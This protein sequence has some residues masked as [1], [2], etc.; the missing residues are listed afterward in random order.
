MATKTTFSDAEFIAL[1]ADYNLGV[2]SSATPIS[3]GTVQTNYLLHP[4]QDRFI[5]RYYENRTPESVIFETNLLNYL[6]TRHFPCPAPIKNKRGKYMSIYRA[7]PFAIF[8]FAEGHQLEHPTDAQQRQLIQHVA[9]LQ[10]ITKGYRPAHRSARWNYGI[11]LC[12]QLA[13]DAAS[14][15]NTP[16]AHAKLAWYESTLQTLQL[17]ASL[18]K[19]IC[20][21]D[22]H[23][24]NVLYKDGD[25]N[26]LIDFDDANYTYLS[27]DLATLINPFIPTFEWNTWMNFQPTDHVFDFTEPRKVVAEYTKHRPLNPTERRHLFDVFKLTI[28][29]DCLWYFERGDV[30][31]FYERRKIDHLDSLGRDSFHF[32]VFD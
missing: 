17:P 9:Q 10:N 21:C 19:G 18:P 25:F 2:F 22:F 31:D 3:S 4:T 8:E 27:Y 14:R 16:N 29:L 28:M 23:F 12:R 7:K 32:A 5:F 1:L 13:R 26:A 20:H 30:N 24:S 15:I 11:P 6:K